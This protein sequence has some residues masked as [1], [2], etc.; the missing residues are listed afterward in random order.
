MADKPRKMSSS[1]FLEGICVNE[2]AIDLIMFWAC[3]EKRMEPYQYHI[4]DMFFSLAS[5]GDDGDINNGLERL[6]KTFPSNFKG[7]LKFGTKTRGNF[8]DS[9]KELDLFK[10]YIEI[11][12]LIVEGKSTGNKELSQTKV[13]K[14]YNIQPRQYRNFRDGLYN[15]WQSGETMSEPD[16]NV[17]ADEHLAFNVSKVV[18]MNYQKKGN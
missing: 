7:D 17:T 9:D 8:R 15:I 3:N 5:I 6:K 2:S 11:S 16:P 14:N 1:E 4:W 13:C 10:K 18:E 12:K